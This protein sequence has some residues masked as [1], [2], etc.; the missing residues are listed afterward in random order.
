[1]WR[2][3]GALSWAR[4]KSD[5]RSVRW[6]DGIDWPLTTASKLPVFR[7]TMTVTSGPAKPMEF[8]AP[9]VAMPLPSS[10]RPATFQLDGATKRRSAV[11]TSTQL[12]PRK[13]SVLVVRTRTWFAPTG[14]GGTLDC[15]VV[16]GALAGVVADVEG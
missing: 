4:T 5:A 2:R 8:P 10:C 7:L 9:M 15:C 13:V 6:K 12:R 16:V 14:A 11:R 1:M 3:M